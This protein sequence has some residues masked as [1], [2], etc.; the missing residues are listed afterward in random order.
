METLEIFTIIIVILA[1]FA[2]YIYRELKFLNEVM[3]LRLELKKQVKKQMVENDPLGIKDIVKLTYEIHNDVH[4]FYE[5]ENNTFV[6]QGK[7]LEE[8]ANHYTTLKGKDILGWFSYKTLDKN[9]CFVN[10]KC[11]EFRNE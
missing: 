7:T 11:L 10:G 4:Y 3:T 1:F 5:E 2:G 8:A 6:A 9:Y